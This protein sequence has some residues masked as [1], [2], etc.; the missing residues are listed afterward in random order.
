MNKLDG[1]IKKI[2]NQMTNKNTEKD[3]VAQMEEFLPY[4]SK[5]LEC[6]KNAMEDL[7]KL[8]SDLSEFFCE[9]SKT[10]KLEECFKSFNQFIG[11]FKKAANDNDKRREQERNAEQR[12][13]QRESDQAKRRSGS[14]QG[15]SYKP[16]RSTLKNIFAGLKDE[17]KDEAGDEVV[18]NNLMHDI[19]E[20]FIQRRLPDGGFKVG[21]RY[22]P[23]VCTV[24]RHVDFVPETVVIGR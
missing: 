13:Q 8:Q 24:M 18:M 2:T 16:A 4:A 12:R 6:L 14:F 19:K 21:Y 22:C 1:Q 7:T 23:C 10:F 5:E 15:I 11:N 9:D 17:E 20:G 3:V